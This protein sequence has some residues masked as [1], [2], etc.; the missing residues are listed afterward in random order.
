MKSLWALWWEI[1][2]LLLAGR[3]RY[4]VGVRLDAEIDEQNRANWIP[5]WIDWHAGEDRF[6][7][8]YARPGP[9]GAAATS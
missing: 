1:T 4:A 9:Y 7:I 8:I 2:K 6:A 3:G 5:A